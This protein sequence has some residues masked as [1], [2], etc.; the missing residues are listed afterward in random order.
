MNGPPLIRV[1]G[2]TRRFG[3][4]LALDGVDLEVRTGEVVG[5][6]GANGAG[7]TTL[8]R[9][10]LGLLPAHAG[11][12]RLF[13]SP[14]SRLTR[15]RLG[16]V[17]QGL[18]LWED[19]SVVEN[20]EFIARAFGSRPPA[21]SDPALAAAAQTLVRDLPL[22][23]RRRLAFEAALAHKPDLLVLDEPTSGVDP[24]ARAR[25]WDTVHDAV[26]SG[27]GALVTTHSMDEA[28]QCDRLVIMSAGIVV[29][30]GSESEITGGRTALAVRADD[31][32]LAF[33]LLDDAGYDVALIGSTLRIP[34]ADP[35]AVGR[36]LAGAGLEVQA[37]LEPATFEEVF[38]AVAGSRAQTGN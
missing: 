33:T 34:G 13:G 22:G 30:S 5:L 14:P 37:A 26:E 10:L 12:V 36:L 31:W 38:V 29:A 27:A 2:V 7:K 19:L 11:E 32:A 16:Y 35:G 8:I 18:G 4:L 28:G 23:L 1:R 25:L 9:I 20:L 24:L 6:L 17:P 3:A 15:R 21:P